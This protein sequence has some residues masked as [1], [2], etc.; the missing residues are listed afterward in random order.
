MIFMKFNLKYL[1]IL[2]FLL[3]F[4]L[5]SQVKHPLDRKSYEAQLDGLRSLKHALKLAVNNLNKQSDNLKSHS[6]ELDE[7]L[8]SC[9]AGL[10]VLKRKLY[11]KKFGRIDGNR[12]AN[13]RVW[14][15]MSEK[16]LKDSWGKPDKIHKNVHPWGVFTQWY[17]GNITYFFKNSKLID[18]REKKN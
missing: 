6:K 8:E 14:K 15:G 4:S 11:V 9:G 7:K 2:I 18:W 3:S 13:G 12:V 1:F 16:M 5:F 10:K 17:Y